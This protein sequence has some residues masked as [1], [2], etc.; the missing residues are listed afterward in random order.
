MLIM[1]LHACVCTRRHACACSNTLVIIY[2]VRVCNVCVFCTDLGLAAAR[3]LARYPPAGHATTT[4]HQG[5][6][7]AGVSG[8]NVM[9]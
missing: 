7:P 6:F 3:G 5:K 2:C 4:I 9:G 1:H 8:T